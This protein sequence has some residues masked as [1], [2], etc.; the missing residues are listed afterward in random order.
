SRTSA[1]TSLVIQKKWT[2]V[3]AVP[4]ARTDAVGQN[5]HSKYSIATTVETARVRNAKMTGDDGALSRMP[6]RSVS[7]ARGGAGCA[8]APGGSF[9]T[10]T[11]PGTSTAHPD[12]AP[13]PPQPRSAS[14]FD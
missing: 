3:A 10:R 9:L 12:G 7:A 6:V 5:F 14:A 1:V 11:I 13:Q 2:G 4:D 8:T